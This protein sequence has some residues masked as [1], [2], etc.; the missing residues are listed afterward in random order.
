MRQPSYALNW[1]D[2]GEP[3]VSGEGIT[4]TSDPDAGFYWVEVVMRQSPPLYSYVRATSAEQ[5]VAFSK[6]RHPHAYLVRLMEGEQ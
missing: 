1:R 6:A 4:R 2:N 3:E 5:A